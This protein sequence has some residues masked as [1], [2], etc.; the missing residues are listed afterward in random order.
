[1]R[2]V[3]RILILSSSEYRLMLYGLTHFCNKLIQ[4]YRYTDTV[5]ELLIKLQSVDPVSKLLNN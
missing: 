3:K 5:D 1:M 2:Q 4:Q